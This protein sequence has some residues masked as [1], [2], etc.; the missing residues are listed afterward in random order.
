MNDLNYPDYP[1]P[2]CGNGGV[3]EDTLCKE[4]GCAGYNH[5]KVNLPSHQIRTEQNLSTLKEI[6]LRM[7]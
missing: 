3:P 6:H 7:V 2:L 4:C 5:G 1:C